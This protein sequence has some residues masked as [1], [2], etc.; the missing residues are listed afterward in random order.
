[1][2]EHIPDGQ[3]DWWIVST[4]CTN[5][6]GTQSTVGG[7]G[8]AMVDLSGGVDITKGGRYPEYGWFWGGGVN[9]CN[10]LTDSGGTEYT[11]VGGQFVTVGNVARGYPFGIADDGTNTI[12]FEFAAFSLPLQPPCGHALGTDA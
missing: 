4:D 3:T 10:T 11:K 2:S 9:P 1:M 6:C 5:T 7:V 12:A 8:V